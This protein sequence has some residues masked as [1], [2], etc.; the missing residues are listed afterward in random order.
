LD[1][2]PGLSP[3]SFHDF[4]ERSL[5]FD[6]TILQRRPINP[7]VGKKFLLLGGV[8]FRRGEGQDEGLAGAGRFI[9]RRAG[10][11]AGLPAKVLARLVYS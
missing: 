2:S 8:L 5:L 6:H 4:R 11:S 7:P 10:T 3:K 9:R 1:P